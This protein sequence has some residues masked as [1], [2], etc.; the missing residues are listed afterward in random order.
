MLWGAH[1]QAKRPV[2]AS[3]ARK[4]DWCLLANHPSPLSAHGARRCRSSAATISA[5]ANAFLVEA[6]G[7]LA[8]STGDRRACCGK[9][10]NN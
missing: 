7:G 9:M 8:L 3:G 5:Q 2:E 1:A 10:R 4:R 6:Q